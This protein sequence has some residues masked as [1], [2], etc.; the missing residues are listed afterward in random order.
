MSD[1]NDETPPEVRALKREVERLQ[2]SVAHWRNESA[3]AAK[4]LEEARLESIKLVDRTHDAEMEVERLN[5]ALGTVAGDIAAKV[6]ERMDAMRAETDAA[7][8][9]AEKAEAEVERLR[10]DEEFRAVRAERD[11]AVV[12]AREE[13]AEVERL[14]ALLAD[15]VEEWEA[16]ART[17]ARHCMREY[18]RRRGKPE[19]HDGELI[20][21]N[22]V[23]D[24]TF[25]DLRARAEVHRG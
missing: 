6:L 10:S 23:Y 22:D 17:Y 19:P 3:E 2:E 24:D 18:A 25:D 9:R 15:Q 1:W 4:R 7:L 14:R 12:A 11:A 5:H 16:A 21:I 20:E 13:R 8:A